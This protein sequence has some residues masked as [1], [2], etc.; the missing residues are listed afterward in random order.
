[1]SE[2]LFLNC[3]CSSTEHVV[4]FYRDE[5]TVALSV[6]LNPY[7]SFWGRVVAAVRFVVGSGWEDRCHWSDT[8]L[9]DDD[10]RKLVEFLG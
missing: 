9:S 7:L 2:Y 4:R 1:M 5:D 6:Q 10:Q 8:I 3:S